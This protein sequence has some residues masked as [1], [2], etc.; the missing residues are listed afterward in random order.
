MVLMLMSK[1][2][3]HKR[4]YIYRR[5]EVM[6][7]DFRGERFYLPQNL[8]NSTGNKKI[9]EILIQNGADVNHVDTKGRAP[10]HWAAASG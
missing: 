2:N 1:M 9:T 4:R 10:L 8:F 5:R 7:K 3:T 6:N